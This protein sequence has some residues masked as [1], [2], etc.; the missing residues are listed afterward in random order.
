MLLMLLQPRRHH[1]P[2]RRGV[3]VRQARRAAARAVRAERRGR[4]CAIVGA[5]GAR[6]RG[7]LALVEGQRG[8]F[9]G[10]GGVAWVIHRRLAV[11]IRKMMA[12]RALFSMDE[13][14]EVSKQSG[15]K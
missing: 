5:V 11:V 6:R 13:V 14:R 8:A 9:E 12:S 3:Y 1:V 7:G 15:N 2:R 10:G 4:E